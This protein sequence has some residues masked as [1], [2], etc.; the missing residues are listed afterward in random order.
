[1]ISALNGKDNAL[2]LA[3]MDPEVISRN[4]QRS[5]A[6]DV[7]VGFRKLDAIGWHCV[8]SYLG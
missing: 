2:K 7:G 6:V 1:M 5:M 3:E 4:W 8:G